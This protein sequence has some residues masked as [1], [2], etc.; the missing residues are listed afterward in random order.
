MRRCSVSC[1]NCD[2]P[3][4]QKSLA[5][6]RFSRFAEILQRRNVELGIDTVLVDFGCGSGHLVKTAL[7]RGI[8]AYGCD[9]DFDQPAYD[10]AVLAEL[11]SANR[12]REV[13]TDRTGSP[14]A[15][16]LPIGEV[17]EEFGH[18]RLPFEDA[19][20][21]V[22]VSTEVLEHVANYAD[23]VDELHR[24]MKPGAVFVHMF[25]PRYALLEGHTN[26]PF[27]GGFKPDWWLKLWSRAGMR[28]WHKKGCPAD[29]Y[30][31][32]TRHYLDNCVY[33]LTKPELIEAFSDSFD[34]EFVER[35][36]FEINPRTRL[37][38]LPSLYSHFRGRVMYGV[39][40][41]DARQ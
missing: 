33:Y 18:Y 7:S 27:G 20:V 11:R 4:D 13:E 12:V 35:D 3:P 2:N 1:V 19:T 29:D 17:A 32:W 8:D 34:L 6:A 14:G 16:Q 9:V 31:T 28:I 26:I 40:R 39:R 37:F 5:E 30:Y 21:D 38:L 25:P 41:S 24:I 22:V 15:D 36:L 23:V 10:Q